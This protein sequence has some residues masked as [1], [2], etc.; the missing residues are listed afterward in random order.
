[1]P[2]LLYASGSVR[3]AYKREERGE[4]AASLLCRHQDHE[5]VARDRR[6]VDAVIGEAYGGHLD[7]ILLPHRLQHLGE[8]PALLIE[9]A[10]VVED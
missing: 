9:G 4:E 1:M 6:E 5:R 3:V 8:R 7:R 2:A 10:H